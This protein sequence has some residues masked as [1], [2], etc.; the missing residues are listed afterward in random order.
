M[1]SSCCARGKLCRISRH[2]HWILGNT[3]T[4]YKSIEDRRFRKRPTS[5]PP[6]FYTKK[7]VPFPNALKLF[8]SKGNSIELVVKQESRQD[9]EY[10]SQMYS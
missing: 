6:A 1:V 10:I 8:Q 4:S 9:Q 3:E 5:H 2:F 7:L